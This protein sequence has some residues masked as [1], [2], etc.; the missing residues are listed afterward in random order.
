MIKLSNQQHELAA[1][2]IRAELKNGD[3]HC[4]GTSWYSNSPATGNWN[5]FIG[6]K[7]NPATLRALESKGFVKVTDSFWRGMEFE[8][9]D[10]DGLIAS[11]KA[12]DPDYWS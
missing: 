7:T 8:V 4:I 6:Q 2:I 11:A 1:C 5:G 9:T 3:R 10:I 12:S